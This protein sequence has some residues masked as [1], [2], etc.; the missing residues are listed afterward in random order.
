MLQHMDVWQIFYNVFSWWF[1]EC[2][3]VFLLVM[4]RTV[5]SELLKTLPSQWRL[6]QLKTYN[7]PLLFIIL[8]SVLIFKENWRRC[9]ILGILS[10]RQQLM[11]HFDLAAYISIIYLVESFN[12]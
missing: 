2:W 7:S 4:A 9:R 12:Q 11:T 5:F 8:P 6:R 10:K 3:F 1:C